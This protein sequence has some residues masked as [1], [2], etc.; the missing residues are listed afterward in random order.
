[1]LGVR[2]E[3]GGAEGY[4]APQRSPRARPH[5]ELKNARMDPRAVGSA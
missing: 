5:E 3:G 4:K 2:S 1:M